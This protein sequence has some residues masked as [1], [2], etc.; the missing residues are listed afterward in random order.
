[1]RHAVV[2]DFLADLRVTGP[3]FEQILLLPAAQRN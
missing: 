3:E 1:L 2:I